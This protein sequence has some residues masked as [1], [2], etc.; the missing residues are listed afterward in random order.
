VEC[1]GVSPG[2]YMFIVLLPDPFKLTDMP[3]LAAGE[4]ERHEEGDD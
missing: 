4:E 3:P 2:L 1:D